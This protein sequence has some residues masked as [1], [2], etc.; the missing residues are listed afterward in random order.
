MKILLLGYSNIAKK[1]FINF[2][3]SKKFTIYIS[4]KSTRE[5]I[6][7]ISKQ[8]NSYE[9]ALNKSDANLV[10]ISLPNSL[11]FKWAYKA[12]ALGYHVVVD[13]PLCNTKFELNKL[14]NI[15][16]HKKKLLA[17]ATFF[18]Y[19]HQFKKTLNLI[20]NKKQIKEIHANF[21]IPKP[22]K[23]TLLA[24]KEFKGGALMDMGP[25]AAAVARIFFNEK[26]V[27]YKTYVKKNKYNLVTSIKFLINYGSKVYS[28]QFKFGGPYENKL[29]II[30]NSNTI[31]L[32]RVFSPP[33]DQNLNL[34]INNKNSQTI[35]K[36]KKDNCFGNFFDEVLQN[37]KK[38]NFN[39]Y[40]DNIKFDNNFRNKIL[41]K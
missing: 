27:S 26:I 8:F 23:N 22:K 12:L 5:K 21:T 19:H 16:K 9:E 2:F 13:K 14:I 36:I 15:S 38:K 39:Y 7:K 40:I 17:E 4:S 28:G 3:N 6:P 25:Y 33:F 30:T 41:K 32:N 35:H 34:I 18:N 11:H 10:Y 20:K 31:I 29:T 1:R 37:I 24:S